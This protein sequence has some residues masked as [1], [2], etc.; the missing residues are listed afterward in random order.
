MNI[1]G[2]VYKR[3]IK[4]IAG[5]PIRE[6]YV[7]RNVHLSKEKRFCRVPYNATRV[8]K[9]ID[10]T[11]YWGAMI[12]YTRD[13][14]LAMKSEGIAKQD[15]ELV[16]VIDGLIDAI[17]LADAA[18]RELAAFIVHERTPVPDWLTAFGG[19]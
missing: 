17:D 11:I 16:T 1:G 4:Y 6:Y 5:G 14:L 18:Q 10:D 12:P 8:M 15:F 7:W 19:K 13:Q 9:A 2:K 3:V